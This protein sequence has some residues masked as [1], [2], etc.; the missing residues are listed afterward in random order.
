MAASTGVCEHGIHVRPG[1][2]DRPCQR[3]YP[4][5]PQSIT[6]CK[7]ILLQ[8]NEG[9]AHS[10]QK[11]SCSKEQPSLGFGFVNGC[12][13]KQGENPKRSP[14]AGAGFGTTGTTMLA[15]VRALFARAVGKFLGL[16]C[17]R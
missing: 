7:Q 3:G 1:L 11:V 6:R 9:E 10:H 16:L 2:A 12:Q 17:F 13:A 5:H 8:V 14:A 15:V 4:A